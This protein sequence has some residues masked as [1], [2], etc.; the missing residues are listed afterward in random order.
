[1]G[2]AV[3]A[4]GRVLAGGA[5]FGSGAG[6]DWSGTG[7]DFTLGRLGASSVRV[8]A[9]RRNR[10]GRWLAVATLHY[11]ARRQG[12]DVGFFVDSD[13][14]GNSDSVLGCATG[15]TAAGRRL[16]LQSVA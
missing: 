10:G 2:A 7:R 8:D 11:E 12:A 16:C 14:A 4:A 6:A 15:A 3:G 5:A 9:L 1:M 13:R